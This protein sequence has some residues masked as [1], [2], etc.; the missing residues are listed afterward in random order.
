MKRSKPISLGAYTAK[1]GEIFDLS[2]DKWIEPSHSDYRKYFILASNKTWGGKYFTVFIKKSKYPQE[3]DATRLA[4]SY[5]LNRVKERLD[6][7]KDGQ[8]PL[9][10]TQSESEGWALI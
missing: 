7:S 10:F 6:I 2:W 5:V 8:L 9:I 3:A 4:T 1:T